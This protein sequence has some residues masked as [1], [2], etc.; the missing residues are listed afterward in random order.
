MELHLS[1]DEVLPGQT[2]T[3]SAVLTAPGVASLRVPAGWAAVKVGQTRDQ[4]VWR[5]TAGG[6]PSLEPVVLTLEVNT[7]EVAQ[8]TARVCCA[9]PIVPRLWLATLQAE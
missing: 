3:A 9:S 5:V 2:I 8:A 4:A 1:T 6:A 7:V